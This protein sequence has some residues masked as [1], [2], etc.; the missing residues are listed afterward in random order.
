[1]LD[2]GGFA[3]GLSLPMIA[4]MRLNAPECAWARDG[5]MRAHLA[6]NFVVLVRGSPLRSLPGF[7]TAG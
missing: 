1:V 6:G 5:L 7:S 2:H 3:L 4:W